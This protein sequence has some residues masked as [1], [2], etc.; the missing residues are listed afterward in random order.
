[1]SAEPTRKQAIGAGLVA[2]AVGIGSAAA[3]YLHPEGLRAP[4]WVAYAA[5]STF[6]LAGAALIAGAFG[7][8]RVVPWLGA[9]IICGLLVPGLWIALGA[10]GRD[11]S[12]SVGALSGSASEIACRAAFGIGA[13]LCLVFLAFLVFLK[14]RG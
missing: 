11:C 14:R 7:A 8:R 4:A 1:V 10:G 9:L 5:V 12:F 6:T 13:L 2:L 3:I